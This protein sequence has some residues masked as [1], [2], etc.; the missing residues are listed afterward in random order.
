MTHIRVILTVQSL[1]KA[2]VTLPLS[3][4]IFYRPEAAVR[5]LLRTAPGPAKSLAFTW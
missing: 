1:I 2:I 5:A 3:C 4:A